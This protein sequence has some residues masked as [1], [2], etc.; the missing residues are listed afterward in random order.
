MAMTLRLSEEQAERLRSTA[1]REHLSMQQVALKA[2]DEYT[3][4]R[5]RRRDELLARIVTEDAAV[6]KR[7][8]KA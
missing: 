1:E 5:T 2:I 7:L 3:L 4:R 8:G 6:L